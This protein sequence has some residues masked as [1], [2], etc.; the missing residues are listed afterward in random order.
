[1][2]KVHPY[3]LPPTIA[4]FRQAREAQGLSVVIVEQP[5]PVHEARRTGRRFR[6]ETYEVDPER[7]RT[8]GREPAGLRCDQGL[9]EAYERN[10]AGARATQVRGAPGSGPTV[11]PCSTHCPLS[12]CVQGY[13]G[14][15]AAGEYHA[16]LGHILARTPLP[17]TVCRVCHRPC[18]AACVRAGI[19]QAVAVNDLKRFVVQWAEQHDQYPEPQRD[20]PSGQQVAVVGAGPSGLAAAHDLA[21]RGHRVTVFDAADRPGGLLAHGIPAY[22][23]PRE[24]LERDLARITRLGVELVNKTRLGQEITVAGLLERGFAAVYLALG[25]QRSR[26]LELAG[27]DAPGAPSLTDALA[28]LRAA[29][30][31]ARATVPEAVVVIGGGNAAIDAAR[32]AR[33]LGAR[34]VTVACLEAR[35][36]MPALPEEIDAALAEG[37]TL[38][39]E[40]MPKRVDRGGVVFGAVDDASREVLL[41]GEEVILAIGQ[42]PDLAPLEGEPGLEGVA[43]GRLA[44][45]PET[46]RTAHERIFGGGDL[47]QRGEGTVTGAIAAG[48][49]AA[50]A[51]DRQLR[52]EE[53]ADRR[54]PPR[55]IPSGGAWSAATIQTERVPRHPPPERQVP[56]RTGSFDEVMGGLSEAEARAEAARCLVCGICGNCRSCIDLCG[57]PAFREVDGR[58]EID[59]VLCNGCGLCLAFCPNDAIRPRGQQ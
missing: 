39:T 5:C 43:Q 25:A 13:T 14:H 51:I 6:E 19:D 28:F 3:D 9:S 2:V 55:Q 7:C 26:P 53:E 4:A 54:P 40:V 18:E 52:G 33:R 10:L 36:A 41:D 44:I 58:I 21:L 32:T 24:A 47:V 38:C 45:D 56:E 29:Q 42:L 16:A 59:Q 50:W 46:G 22:R 37:I 1:V 34:Q 30:T 35:A 48:L 11:A 8:C 17:E 23:L 31:E 57:C 12:L 27:A 49:R 20:P 15:I